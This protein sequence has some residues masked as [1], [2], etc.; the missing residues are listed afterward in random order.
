MLPNRKKDNNEIK[1]KIIVCEGSSDEIVL[2]ALAQ[3]LERSITTVVA[4]GKHNISAYFESIK[5]SI[6]ILNF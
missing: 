5:N 4:G 1:K 3:K 2:Q 6:K